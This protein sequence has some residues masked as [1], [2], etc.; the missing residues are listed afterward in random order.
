MKKK[1]GSSVLF[2][3][4]AVLTA[5]LAVTLTALFL[6]AQPLLLKTP[7]AA[8][9]TADAFMTAVCDGNFDSAQKL[10][11]GSPELGADRAPADTAG[12]LIWDA[13]L[14]STDYSLAGDCYTVDSGLA[15]DVLFVS[16]DMSSVT[17]KL[18]QRAETLLA[19]K[20]SQAEDVSDIY[21]EDNNYREELVMEVLE[22]VTE[23]AIREDSRYSEQRITLKLTCQ[24]G[25]WWVQPEQQ[26]LNVLFGGI[27]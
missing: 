23:Q 26:L 7:E 3:V 24:D 27:G 16:M 11:Y 2:A 5:A 15:I 8:I 13:F 6:H 20:V 12:V 22:T 25:Q 19:R 18:G 14:D 10:L 21:D 9:Q 4:L 17:E 1:C